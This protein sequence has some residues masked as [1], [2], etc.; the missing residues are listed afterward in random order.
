MNQ[1]HRSLS[2]NSVNDGSDINPELTLGRDTHVRQV[3]LDRHQDTVSRKNRRSRNHGKFKIGTWNVNTLYQSG[4]MENVTQEMTRLKVDILGISEARWTG[5]GKCLTENGV[6][7]YSGGDQHQNG[8]GIFVN[9]KVDK[10]VMGVWPVTER[11]IMLKI[12]GKPINMNI[13]QVYAPTADSSEEDIEDFYRHLNETFA[14][15]KPQE[16]TFIIGDLNAKVGNER[17]GTTV[18]PF[19]LG[20]CND[21]GE[22]WTDW[23]EEKKLA[24]MNTWFKHHPRHLWTWKRAGDTYRNQIDYIAISKRFRSAVTQTRTFPGAD[25]ASDHV[26]VIA[27]VRV[28][29]KNITKPKNTPKI[30]VS[31]LGTNKELQ[32]KYEVEIYNRFE[33][34]EEIVWEDVNKGWATIQ[35]I[36]VETA[37]KI[38]PKQIKRSK[39]K[40]M[41]QEILELMEE[42]RKCKLKNEEKY[43][44]LN[45]KIKEECIKAKEEWIE[46]QCDEVHQLEKRNPKAMYEKIKELTGGKRP[47]RS[48]TIKNKEGKILMETN[49]VLQRWSQYIDDLFEDETR[50]FPEILREMEGPEILKSEIQKAMKS[51]KTG[52]SPGDDGVMIEMLK[53]GGEILLDKITTIA[54]KV[55]NTGIIPEEMGKSVFIAIPKKAGTTDCEQHRTLSL[56]SH[57]TKIIL[58]VIL[59]RIKPKLEREIGEEQYGFMKDKGTTNAIYVM[60]NFGERA[61]EMQKN[62]FLCFIDYEKAFDRVQHEKLFNM[63]IETDI[64][65]KDLRLIRNLYWNQKAAVDIDKRKTEWKSIKRG[66]R[67]GCV[68][69]PILF[70]YYGEIILRS[71]QDHEGIKIGGVNINNVRYADDTVLIADTTDKLQNLV[72]IVN[73]TSELYGLKINKKKTETMVIT[74][75]KDIPALNIKINN[76]NIKQVNNFKYLGSTMTSD[77]RSTT[78]IKKRIGIAKTAFQKMRPLLTN[79]KLNIKTRI[80]ALKTYV[81]STLT[82]GCETWTQNK[83]I[84]DRL[85]AFEM[86]TLR[87]MLKIPWTARKTNIQVLQQAETQRELMQQINRRQLKFMGHVTRKKKIEHLSIT[88]KIEGRRARGR[89]RHKIIDRMIERNNLNFTPT[90]LIQMTEDRRRWRDMIAQVS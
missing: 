53:A 50:E 25:C 4:K 89:Q 60:R 45:S 47:T 7:Y 38:L 64:D 8:V 76:T 59:E 18:G 36:V 10:A 39:N 3:R 20:D 58:K 26:P 90:Q 43:T 23:C 15:C 30:D 51:M 55:Y 9:K 79:L 29:L 33:C 35:N 2:V 73:E 31:V 56:M 37:N 87:R 17:R 6:F 13:I 16:I 28:R 82:Y 62:L 19:G 22:K 71:I 61:I 88:G 42:R 21:R 72:N 69:S 86:W 68:L 24:V 70:S 32:G 74:K 78:E 65:S 63:L 44:E 46:K 57:I 52:K 54:N 27:N 77:G 49:E 80:R 84:Q 12:Q 66:V 81:W 11:I 48:S 75:S 83:E 14:Q 41:K 40:W 5:K 85:E 67:Q 34:L 1:N